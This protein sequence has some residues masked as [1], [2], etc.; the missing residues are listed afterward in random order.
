[1]RRQ[2]HLQILRKE[3]T[4]GMDQSQRIEHPLQ[5]SEQQPG[6]ARR[7]RMADPARCSGR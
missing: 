1:M 3:G 4:T 5:R 2:R 7:L 6:K